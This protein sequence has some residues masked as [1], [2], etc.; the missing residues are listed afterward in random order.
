MHLS[1]CLGQGA[2]LCRVFLELDEVRVECKDDHLHNG[3]GSQK[4]LKLF[5]G[6]PVRISQILR[7]PRVSGIQ[8]ETD[9]GGDVGVEGGVDVELPHGVNRIKTGLLKIERASREL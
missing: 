7:N 5:L 4:L 9:R 6:L 2:L 1:E 3:V 8:F